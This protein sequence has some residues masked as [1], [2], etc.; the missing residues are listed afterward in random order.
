MKYNASTGAMRF[1]PMSK[2]A[3]GDE[4]LVVIGTAMF[5]AN[6]RRVTFSKSKVTYDVDALDGGET[7]RNVDSVFVES[8]E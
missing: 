1:A 3:P 4:V 8:V 2:F 7:V 5:L 6:V